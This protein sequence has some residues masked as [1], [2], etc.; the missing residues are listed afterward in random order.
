M[1]SI[2]DSHPTLELPPGTEI[3]GCRIEGVAGRGGMAAVYRGVD[4][5]LGRPVA[6][7]VFAAEAE[8][9]DDAPM[10]FG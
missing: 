10:I 9:L 1:P 6:V 4:L 8:G 2:T 3:A 5:A 7:K